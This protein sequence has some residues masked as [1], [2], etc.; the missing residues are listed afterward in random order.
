MFS[1][2]ALGAGEGGQMLSL[3][4]LVSEM[5]VSHVHTLVSQSFE[6][7][8]GHLSHIGKLVGLDRLVDYIYQF[9]K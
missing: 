6:G 1:Q 9:L 5:T 4:K 7:I 2:I 3:A 8:F